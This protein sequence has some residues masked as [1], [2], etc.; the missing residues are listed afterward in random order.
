MRIALGFVLAFVIGVLCRRFDVPL[1]GPSRLLG[2]LLVMTLTLGYV[3]TD[4][5]L[6]ARA[7]AQAV[8][9]A[10]GANAAR[11]DTPVR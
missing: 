11:D 2:A 8:E 6:A 1:P 7:G 4:R 5:L 9:D 10:S 3:V